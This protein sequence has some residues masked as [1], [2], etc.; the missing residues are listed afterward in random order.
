MVL[1]KVT[2]DRGS[3][4]DVHDAGPDGLRRL[5][6][7]KL[8]D[9]DGIH[10]VRREHLDDAL[11]VGRGKAIRAA[12]LVAVGDDAADRVGAGR[13]SRPRAAS[14]R[15]RRRLARASSTMDHARHA[16]R[17]SRTRRS[18][19][20]RR[21]PLGAR[22]RRPAP[23]RSGSR[24]RRR[25]PSRPGRRR[26]GRARSARDSSRQAPHRTCARRPPQRPCARR[27]PPCV[28][29]WSGR[30]AQWAR[31]RRSGAGRR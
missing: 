28:R 17:R 14:R 21:G 24:L 31:R 18:R 27:A 23:R 22:G 19:A 15:K 12:A 9:E 8:V 13:G 26:A 20:P 3:N 6:I 5:A 10:A 30:A 2:A 11:E 4:A 16:R 29:A 1:A 7:A 25:R